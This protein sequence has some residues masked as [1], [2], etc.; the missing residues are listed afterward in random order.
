MRF[1]PCCLLLMLL[2]CSLSPVHGVLESPY[3]S[4]RCLCTRVTR[5][6]PRLG[7]VKRVKT[8]PPG[9]GCPRM[10]IIAWLKNKAIL[11][12][13]PKYSGTY[14]LLKAMQKCGPSGKSTPAQRT[15]VA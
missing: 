5:R 11:C 4:F 2:V 6:T 8:F 14:S 3:T 13:D 7:L 10:E 9:N 15:Q 1:I 12:L